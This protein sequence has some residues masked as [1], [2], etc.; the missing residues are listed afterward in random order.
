MF[1]ISILKVL[2]RVW[3]HIFQLLKVG[4]AS[5]PGER[6]CV[7]ARL[8]KGSGA[9]LCRIQVPKTHSLCVSEVIF[10]PLEK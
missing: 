1:K 4:G 9:K 10:E 5:G 6:L 3:V 8:R 2:L 7:M